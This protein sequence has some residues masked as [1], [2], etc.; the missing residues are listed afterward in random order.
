MTND[1]LYNFPEVVKSQ[2]GP[3]RAGDPLTVISVAILRVLVEIA[4]RV[5][6]PQTRI[7]Q[8]VSARERS[9]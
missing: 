2:L 5:G 8:H 7:E 1:E 3:L 9:K 4:I 6:K